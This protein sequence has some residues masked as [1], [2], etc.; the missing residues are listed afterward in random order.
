MP[1]LPST[2]N[3]P[4]ICEWL[5]YCD[6]HPQRSGEDLAAHAEKFDREGY[7]R[8]NQLART[9]VSI[10]KLSE[11]LG[12]GKGT[13]DLLIQYAEEDIELVKAGNFSMGG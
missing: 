10:E 2:I 11:W 7:R 6:T 8:I 13:A 3:Y 1:P 9:R 5:L 4:K 12:I